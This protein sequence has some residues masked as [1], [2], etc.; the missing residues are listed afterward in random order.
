MVD[1]SPNPNSPPTPTLPTQVHSKPA[2]RERV[3]SPQLSSHRTTPLHSH[4]QRYQNPRGGGR[5]S[6]PRTYYPESSRPENFKQTTRT[7]AYFVGQSHMYKGS[8]TT[9]SSHGPSTSTL[10]PSS[11]SSR[12]IPS[13]IP[14]YGSGSLA[15][16]SSASM[17]TATSIQ[18]SGELRER[19]PPIPGAGGGDMKYEHSVISVNSTL[20]DPGTP[21][22]SSSLLTV[23]NDDADNDTKEK[24]FVDEEDEEY[25]FDPND[26]NALL[27]GSFWRKHLSARGIDPDRMEV[28]SFMDDAESI[29]FSHP[30]D[31]SRDTLS[32]EFGEEEELKKH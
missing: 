6:T 26:P 8:K 17:N 5:Q 21:S 31:M 23:G 18:S 29:K 32:L 11:L 3:D 28:E 10:P 25:T 13:S 22:T 27:S 19:F 4:A 20:I 14:V 30:F 15:S 7:L 9:G 12:S 1:V 24:P 16:P 2:S